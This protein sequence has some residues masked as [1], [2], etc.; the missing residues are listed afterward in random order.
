MKP[1]SQM[2]FDHPLVL[3]LI[4]K[5]W[6]AAV[7]MYFATVAINVV[8]LILLTVYLLVVVPPYNAARY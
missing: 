8:W 3:A 1:D 2:L 5:K 4:R 6:S 7:P